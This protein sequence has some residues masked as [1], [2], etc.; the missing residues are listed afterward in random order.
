[1]AIVV[2]FMGNTATYCAHDEKCSAATENV[3]LNRHRVLKTFATVQQ[4]HDWSD[5]DEWDKRDDDKPVKGCAKFRICACAK[6]G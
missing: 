2:V 5:K 4:A 6:K 1:M 3:D